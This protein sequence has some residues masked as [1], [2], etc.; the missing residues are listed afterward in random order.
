[1]SKTFD[2]V[3]NTLDGISKMLDDQIEKRGKQIAKDIID[4]LIDGNVIPPV[5]IKL[6][7]LDSNFKPVG[8]PEIAIPICGECDKPVWYP[9]EDCNNCECTCHEGFEHA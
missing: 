6:Q 2:N 4:G 7:E 5:G 9:P 1:M 3:P 8:A